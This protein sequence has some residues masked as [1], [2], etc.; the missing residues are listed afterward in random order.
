[1]ALLDRPLVHFLLLG[2]AVFC[3]RAALAEPQPSDKTIHVTA[4]I[5]S[6]VRSE[7][8]V[9][10]GREA[11]REEYEVA[12]QRWKLDEV[13]Y[14][15]ALRMRLDDEDPVVRRQLITKFL[16]VN[17]RLQPLPEPTKEELDAWLLS[18]RDDY[19]AKRRYDFEHRFVRG[20]DEAAQGRAQA[21]LDALSQGESAS[22]RGDEFHFGRTFL[23]RAKESIEVEFGP[24]FADELVTIALGKWTLLRSKHGFH[25]VRV[26]RRTGG[27][28]PERSALTR[29]LERDFR[30][31][32][33]HELFR[34]RLDELTRSYRFVERSP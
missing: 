31:H 7:L 24:E 6:E 10:L 9:G 26:N 13:A 14:R 33:R 3:I 16:E 18:H 1:V 34:R 5:R 23:S 2:S 27:K 8:Q 29:T 15:E 11:T 30:E 19:V 21:V 25:V 12:L 20:T 22:D 32:A 28:A 4:A 17:L